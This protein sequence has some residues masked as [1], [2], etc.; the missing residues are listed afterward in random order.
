MKTLTLLI[1][2]ASTLCG[3]E[4]AVVEVD[5][6]A[7]VNA[8]TLLGGGFGGIAI[9]TPPKLNIQNPYMPSSGRQNIFNAPINQPFHPANIFA[10][11]G[12]GFNEIRDPT[13]SIKVIYF[14][15]E[16]TNSNIRFFR[17]PPR[18]FFIVFS[19]TFGRERFIGAELMLDAMMGNKLMVQEALFINNL[20][21]IKNVL[22]I[23][24]FPIQIQNSYPNL[25]QSILS[26][27]LM[28]NMNLGN[29]TNYNPIFN[30]NP[31]DPA[32]PSKAIMAGFQKLKNMDVN[33]IRR[34]DLLN[35]SQSNNERIYLFRVKIARKPN[36]FYAI[37]G[38]LNFG[39]FKVIGSCLDNN[40]KNVLNYLK[41][42]NVDNNFGR[43]YP[44]LLQQIR[45]MNVGGFNNNNGYNNSGFSNNNGYNNVNLPV[46]VNNGGYTPSVN[47]GGYTPPVNNG[48]F[49]PNNGFNYPANNN[50]FN[51]NQTPRAVVI[52]LNGILGSSAPEGLEEESDEEDSE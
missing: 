30:N 15:E 28:N 5:K 40:R 11:I 6:N 13:S 18:K 24:H 9:V 44:N 42:I 36:M 23:T 35:Y 29:S 45:N 27:P 3:D 26:N 25:K 31:N 22:K 14:A 34:I 10:T 21:I 17:A 38:N 49:M 52:P 41:G 20:N 12:N 48:G 16:M 7:E 37:R 43:N 2:I 32:H 47:N 50:Q 51:V 1:L 46:P 19:L 39:N 4:T 8:D 33:S